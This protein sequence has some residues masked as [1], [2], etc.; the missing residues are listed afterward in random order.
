[1]SDRRDPRLE[2]AYARAEDKLDVYYAKRRRRGPPIL[3]GTTLALT[4]AVGTVA[5]VDLRRLQTP[6]GTALAWTGAAIFGDCT[7]YQALSVPDPEA[8]RPDRRTDDELCLDLRRQ[9]A[10]NRDGAAQI[11]IDV[12]DMS[13]RGSDATALLSVRRP[14][15]EDQI[16]LT[17]RRHGDGWA[18]VRTPELCLAVG[19]A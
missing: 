10:S 2:Q 7:A 15:G 1:M 12:L 13:R 8:P 14:E 4:L 6:T 17:M 3:L 16:E 18:V 11:G 19:C 5:A 9:T